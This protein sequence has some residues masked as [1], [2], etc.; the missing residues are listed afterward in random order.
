VK[1]WQ[2]ISEESEKW[3]DSHPEHQGSQTET[4]LETEFI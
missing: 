1:G 4:V 2:E 3:I